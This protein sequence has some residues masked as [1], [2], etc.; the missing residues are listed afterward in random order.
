ML[1]M[2]DEV[3]ISDEIT[4]PFTEIDFQ[5]VRARGPGGQNVNKVATAVHLRFDVRQSGALPEMVRD[6]LLALGDRRLTADGVLVIKSQQFRSPGRNRQAALDRLRE[7]I[8]SV[9]AEPKLRKPTR[10]G[11]RSQQERIDA[12]RRRG[13]LKQT[14][15][16]IPGD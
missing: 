16:K 12:K 6:R 3:I 2:S 13:Q 11:R 8:Q 7:L 10:P 1:K 15:S 4:I 5:A 14:R 9:L